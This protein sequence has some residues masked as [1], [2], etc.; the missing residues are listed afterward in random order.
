MSDHVI[1]VGTPQPCDAS[2]W[3]YCAVVTGQ[4]TAD[5]RQWSHIGAVIQ[6]TRIQ[7]K[8]G[9]KHWCFLQLGRIEFGSCSHHKRTVQSVCR[10]GPGPPP[11][12]GLGPVV[13]VRRVRLTCSHLPK[14][15]A[16]TGWTLQGP[17]QLSWT[18]QA[19]RRP[20]VPLL[21]LKCFVNNF[22]FQKWVLK[23][24]PLYVGAA[25]EFFCWE[26]LQPEDCLWKRAL[27][28]VWT[29][30]LSC[31]SSKKQTIEQ[32]CG[33]LVWPQHCDSRLPESS[34]STSCLTVH[35]DWQSW[36]LQLR[37]W[38]LWKGVLLQG[39][40][41]LCVCFRFDPL[42][43]KQSD[44]TTQDRYQPVRPAHVSDFIFFK[45]I[46]CVRNLLSGQWTLFH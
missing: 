9:V 31:F 33:K 21:D 2:C 1:I 15:T 39:V 29:H 34:V 42:L 28:C 44:E 20:E 24:R 13:S 6:W 8:F 10:T 43:F 45:F 22:Y 4:R 7:L 23:F 11:Q 26:K 38:F 19:W 27:I 37:D 32:C 18:R 41:C 3:P 12:R 16:P 17:V 5:I 40:T 25:P 35:M 46:K 14:R 36:K 30:T